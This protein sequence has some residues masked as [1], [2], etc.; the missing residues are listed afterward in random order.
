MQKDKQA[1]FRRKIVAKTG[2]SEPI[3]SIG[4]KFDLIMD[5]GEL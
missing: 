5:L 3:K 4:Y 2:K 1:I